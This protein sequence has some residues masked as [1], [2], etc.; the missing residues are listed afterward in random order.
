MDATDSPYTFQY[1][2]QES[3]FVLGTGPGPG[4]GKKV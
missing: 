1:A 2:F 3:L 4:Q